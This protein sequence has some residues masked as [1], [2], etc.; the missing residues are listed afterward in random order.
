MS[1]NKPTRPTVAD[2]CILLNDLVQWEAFA[3]QLPGIASYHIQA[4]EYD[5]DVEDKKRALYEAWMSVY[6]D[7]SWEDVIKALERAKLNFHAKNVRKTISNTSVHPF[8]M[9]LQQQEEV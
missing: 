4:I 5:N 2:L 9:S 7:A 1:T 3:I 8:A 6:P